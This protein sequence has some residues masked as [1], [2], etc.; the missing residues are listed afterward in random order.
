MLLTKISK[1]L[2]ENKMIPKF[3][4]S[5]LKTR[6]NESENHHRYKDFQ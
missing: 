4:K 6:F 2:L 3:F 1:I 5:L